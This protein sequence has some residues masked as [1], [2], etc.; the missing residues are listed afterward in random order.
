[1]NVPRTITRL[2]F[3]MALVP[4]L[5]VAQ[6]PPIGSQ[7]RVPS[8]A[9]SGAASAPSWKPAILEGIG[10]DSIAVRYEDGT[11]DLLTSAADVRIRIGNHG[12]AGFWMGA[13]AGAV[14]GAVSG[15]TAERE[16]T[17]AVRSAEAAI[18]CWLV[19]RC[20]SSSTR[21]SGGG[22]SVGA[23][24]GG[25]LTLGGLGWLIGRGVPR[26]DHLSKVTVIPEAHGFSARIE[27]P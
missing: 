24:I 26:W 4:G 11:F 16:R 6:D 9:A 22:S 27:G 10:Q 23:V 1:M 20:D 15:A 19:G 12:R 8:A 2:L 18:T 3:L 13:V 25:A 21:R 17:R 5:A 14:L 7:L